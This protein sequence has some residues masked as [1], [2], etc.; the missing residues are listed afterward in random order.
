VPSLVAAWPDQGWLRPLLLGLVAVVVL[1][2][3]LRA[4]LQS[5]LVIGGV[6][7]VLAA[8]RELAAPAVRLAGV[9]PGWVPFAVIGAGLLATG[10][11]YEAR[12]RDLARLRAALGRLS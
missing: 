10:A 7:A 6:V 1:L 9:L 8:G 2:A 11:T 3:G 4:R 12:M 5:P